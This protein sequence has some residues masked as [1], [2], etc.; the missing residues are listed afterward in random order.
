MTRAV[1]DLIREL[2]SLYVRYGADKFE[3]ALNELRRGDVVKRINVLSSE[4]GL[5]AG[6]LPRDRPQGSERVRAGKKETPK[7]ALYQ[8]V[9]SL[10][11]TGKDKDVA[12][13]SFID[14]ISLRTALPTLR[15]LRDYMLMLG[16]VVSSGK[17][18][19]LSA[20]RRIASRLLQ[21]PF[22][23]VT[24]KLVSAEK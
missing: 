17:L 15:S 9:R 22:E 4:I 1:D 13:A 8:Y 16:I 14:E 10:K 19:R 6:G 12:V 7:E 21:M 2:L 5:V 11:E 18:D 20:A 3:A 24:R 23:E